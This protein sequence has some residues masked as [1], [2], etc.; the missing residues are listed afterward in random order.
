ML[1]DFTQQ[2]HIVAFLQLNRLQ[3]F[4]FRE[5]TT[6]E[7]DSENM[8]LAGLLFLAFTLEAYLD[9][10]GS[11]VLPDWSK[12]ATRLSLEEKLKVVSEHLGLVFDIESDPWKAARDIRKLRNPVAHGKDSILEYA[13]RLDGPV[14]LRGFERLPTEWQRLASKE[15]AL[16][17]KTRVEALL[18]CINTAVYDLPFS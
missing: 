1:V 12:R 7:A 14:S 5:A 8:F 18:D 6:R 2:T 10:I 9:H 3:Q 11:K 15:Q 4:F 17:L 16:G 13:T